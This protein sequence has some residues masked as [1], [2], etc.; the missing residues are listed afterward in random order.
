MKN[1]KILAGPYLF[2][3]MSFII[4]PLLMILY[5]GLTDKNGSFTL[6]NLSQ[7]T[8]PENLKALGLALLLSF[9]STLICLVLAYPLAMILAEKN[10]NQTSFIVLIFIL[11]MWMNFLLRTLAWQT[12]LE[13][14]GVINSILNFLHLPEQSILHLPLF[15]EW[16]TI[17]FLLWYFRSTMCCLRLIKM[18]STLPEISVRTLRR[19]FLRS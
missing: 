10:M 6:N 3:A 9:I 4:I 2:W 19:H 1:R 7:M 16:Y 14:N 13:K 18:L 15:S 17:F 12:L 11:P 8:T 5:Y